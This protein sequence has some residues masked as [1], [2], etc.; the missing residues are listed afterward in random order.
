MRNIFTNNMRGTQWLARH[1]ARK[2][3]TSN[4]YACKNLQERCLWRNTG[5]EGYNIKM[6]THKKN[7]CID[8]A[9]IMDEWRSLVN[10]VM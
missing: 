1:A 8:L 7:D 3:H 10:S 4:T 5:A 6:D 9:Q 2:G